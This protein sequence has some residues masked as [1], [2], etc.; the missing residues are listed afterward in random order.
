MKRWGLSWQ[1]AD[2]YLD[3]MRAVTPEQIRAVA[4]EYLQD[5][6]LTV[7]VLE[8]QSMTPPNQ[9]KEVAHD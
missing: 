9:A 8:P 2:Q 3:K 6:G 5:E 7:G 1:L 4:I